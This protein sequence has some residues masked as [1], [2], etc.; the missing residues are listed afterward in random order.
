LG[1]KTLFATHYHELTALEG[2]LPGI[3]N[4]SIAC[5]KHGDTVTF[6]RRIVRGGAD[7]S[8][9][10]E[11]AAL[12]GLPAKLIARAKE[13]LAEIESREGRPQ[14]STPQRAIEE[15]GQLAIS[16]IRG[17]EIVKRLEQ[18]DVTT[19]TPIEALNILY[20]LQNKAKS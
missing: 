10:I 6:L 11:V 14:Q 2:M 15:D 13:I 8:Y 17:E 20:E 12:A 7:D 1:A 18:L 5:K 19:L 4:Y 16:D 3:K 9:G